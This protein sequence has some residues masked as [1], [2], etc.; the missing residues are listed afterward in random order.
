MSLPAVQANLEAIVMGGFLGDD[1]RVV[2]HRP[3]Q[4][5]RMEALGLELVWKREVGQA[6]LYVFTH[7][8]E[9]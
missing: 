1:G 5:S 8:E 2:L 9:S 6:Q 7:E 4:E 3:M